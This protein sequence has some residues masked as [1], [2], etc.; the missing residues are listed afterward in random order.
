MVYSWNEWQRMTSRFGVWAA[1]NTGKLEEQDFV[2]CGARGRVVE[3]GSSNTQFSVHEHGYCEILRMHPSGDAGRQMDPERVGGWHTDC[4]YRHNSG[5]DH[6][7]WLKIEQK[8]QHFRDWRLKKEL[9]AEAGWPVRW[10]EDE[11]AGALNTTGGR[12]FQEEV[13]WGTQHSCQAKGGG[14]GADRWFSQPG[15]HWWPWWAC[16]MAAAE[17]KA[18]VGWG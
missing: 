11:R 7:G 17:E 3:K 10:E 8:F 5:T 4:I 18:L 9:A 1:G 15:D 6:R 14:P 13:T 12:R 16:S 2:V